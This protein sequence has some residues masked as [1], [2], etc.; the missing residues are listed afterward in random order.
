MAEI[1]SIIKA[2]DEFVS[3]HI[4]KV[5]MQELGNTDIIHLY[6]IGEYLRAF[7]KSAYALSLIL[8]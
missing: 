4:K 5:L 2:L 8:P 3:M 7:D 1:T 6:Y